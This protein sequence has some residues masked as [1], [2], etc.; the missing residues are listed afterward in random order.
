MYLHIQ[1]FFTNQII[2]KLKN[3]LRSKTSSS[4][5]SGL[6]KVC[7]IKSLMDTATFVIRRVSLPNIRSRAHVLSFL[8]HGAYNV[9]F[10][11]VQKLQNGNWR[12]FKTTTMISTKAPMEISLLLSQTS[13]LD[14]EHCLLIDYDKAITWYWLWLSDYHSIDYD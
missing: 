1:T 5:F 11:W 8:K 4:Y 6:W 10:T 7:A 12:I 9:L 13:M 3:V 14:W 2:Y